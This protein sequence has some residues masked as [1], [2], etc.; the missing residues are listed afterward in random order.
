MFAVLSFLFL[1][2]MASEDWQRREDATDHAR[3]WGMVF[4]LLAPDNHPNPEV[5]NR[6]RRAKVGYPH[7]SYSFE[8]WLRRNDP[9]LRV[10]HQWVVRNQ[11]SHIY[12]NQDI[13]LEISKK[14]KF[15]GWDIRTWMEVPGEGLGYQFMEQFPKF[16]D[17]IYSFYPD[18]DGYENFDHFIKKGKPK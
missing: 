15:P 17:N 3:R 1:Q 11:G 18:F 7:D 4:A 14:T 5:S 10:W 13:F 16:G 12:T 2:G 6:I 8:Y 9:T